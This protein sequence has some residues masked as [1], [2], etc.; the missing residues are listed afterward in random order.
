MRAREQPITSFVDRV[1]QLLSGSERVEL[2]DVEQLIE[3]AQTKADGRAIL[4]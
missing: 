4:H 3:T 1:R 2:F